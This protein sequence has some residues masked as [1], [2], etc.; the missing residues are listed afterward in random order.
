MLLDIKKGIP[1]AGFNELDCME[2]QR[3]SRKEE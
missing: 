2:N 3:M 1:M